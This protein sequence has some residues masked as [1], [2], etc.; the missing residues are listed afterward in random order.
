MLA[1][2]DAAMMKRLCLSG[3]QYSMTTDG[4]TEF[5]IADTNHRDAGQFQTKFSDLHL[6]V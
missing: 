3:E 6:S 4:S 1:G 5:R 2:C